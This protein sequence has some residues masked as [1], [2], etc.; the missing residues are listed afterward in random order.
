MSAGEIGVNGV[1][2]YFAAELGLS[3]PSSRNYEFSGMAGVGGSSFLQ[4]PVISP[5]SEILKK[6]PHIKAPLEIIAKS[7]SVLCS[8]P[9]D[10][11][12]SPITKYIEKHYQN[13]GIMENII[14]MESRLLEISEEYNTEMK[15]IREAEKSARK[16][17]WK[18]FGK[19]EESDNKKD[20]LKEITAVIFNNMQEGL[21]KAASTSRKYEFYSGAGGLSDITLQTDYSKRDFRIFNEKMHEGSGWFSANLSAT[22]FHKSDVPQDLKTHPLVG[23]LSVPE[24]LAELSISFG[25]LQVKKNNNDYY[26]VLM[27]KDSKIDVEI[28]EDAKEIFI[29]K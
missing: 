18:I 13:L 2:R 12:S 10:T 22:I 19:K 1:S 21:K 17:S 28:L 14:G 6:V 26:E 24:N 4:K 27:K 15:K 25:G 23:G 7:N 20:S 8:L 5:I 9:Y 29:A 16:K 3:S 11:D